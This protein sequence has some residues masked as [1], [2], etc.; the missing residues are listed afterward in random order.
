MNYKKFSRI[1]LLS[2][3]PGPNDRFLAICNDGIMTQDEKWLKNYHAVME[4]V[5]TRHVNQYQ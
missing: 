3:G 4:Y 2:S 1:Y 5:E